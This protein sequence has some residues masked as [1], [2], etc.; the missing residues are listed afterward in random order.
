M[1]I[2]VISSDSITINLL[3]CHFSTLLKTKTSKKNNY[4]NLRMKEQIEDIAKKI[5]IHREL[6]LKNDVNNTAFGRIYAKYGNGVNQF[7]IIKY[8]AIGNSA[9]TDPT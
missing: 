1:S 8:Q 7:W 3:N 4:E 9:Q 5:K 2:Y 6:E